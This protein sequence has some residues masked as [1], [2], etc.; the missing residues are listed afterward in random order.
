M[1]NSGGGGGLAIFLIFIILLIA[2]GLG[3]WFFGRQ[4]I[5]KNKK[6]TTNVATWKPDNFGCIPNTCVDKMVMNSTKDDCVAA[7]PAVL[8]T[9]YTTL[10]TPPSMCRG[11]STACGV[12]SNFKNIGTTTPPTYSESLSLDACKTK[13][14][15]YTDCLAIDYVDKSISPAAAG[16]TGDCYYY[17]NTTKPTNPS[18]CTGS[19]APNEQCYIRS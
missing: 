7:S 5:C 15:T 18:A 17:T 19:V 1:S 2:G 14:N 12:E 16:T 4:Y 10:G 3:Y 9:T 8:G 11:I 6:A 13:C